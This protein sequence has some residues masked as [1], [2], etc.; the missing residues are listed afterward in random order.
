VGKSTLLNRLAGDDRAI[1][2]AAPGTTRDVLSIDIDIDGLLMRVHDTAG[3]RDTTDPVEI[4]GVRRAKQQL[5]D[6]DAVLYVYA[7]DQEPQ[8]SLLDAVSAPV[9]LIRNKI[10]ITGERPSLTRHNN[11]TRISLS[12]KTGD[13]IT[14]LTQAILTAF[15]LDGDNDSTLLARDRHLTALSEACEALTFDHAA[16][17]TATP[18]LG[19][20]HLRLAGIALGRLT[21]EFTSDDLLG[22]IFST[23]CLGK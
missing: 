12:A 5:R 22:E 15:H 1:V 8:S 23:F 2:N 6:A 17:Y 13:G 11:Q 16:F 21:G 10:D 18:E 9:F 14:Q 20:E 7:D 3:I 19:A 4:E